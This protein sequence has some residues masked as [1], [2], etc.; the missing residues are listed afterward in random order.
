[1]RWCKR[2][3]RAAVPMA[4]P[5]PWATHGGSGG[6][7]TAK[8]HVG[9]GRQRRRGTA[10]PGAHGALRVLH[11]VLPLTRGSS[12]P[13]TP[14]HKRRGG[15][16]AYVCADFGRV[17]GPATT[18]SDGGLRLVYAKE[19]RALARGPSPFGAPD[20]VVVFPA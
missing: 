19:V 13:I 3:T 8:V 12:N 7:V 14:S 10:L 17:E 11:R 2:R 4:R 6:D 18:S 20:R 1:M 5:A 16:T 9:T 15:D